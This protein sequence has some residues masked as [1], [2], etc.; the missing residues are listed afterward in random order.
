MRLRGR[1]GPRAGIPKRM[2]PN[3]Q[4]RKY[5][6]TSVDC[7]GTKRSGGPKTPLC[8]GKGP[9]NPGVVAPFAVAC[10]RGKPPSRRTH[11]IRRCGVVLPYL[12]RYGWTV[13]YTSFLVAILVNPFEGNSIKYFVAEDFC[14]SAAYHLWGSRTIPPSPRLWFSSSRSLRLTHLP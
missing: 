2:R 7:V 13:A 5:S 4:Q 14:L 3:C 9:E 11:P 12:V 8:E 10:C 1:L 6:R